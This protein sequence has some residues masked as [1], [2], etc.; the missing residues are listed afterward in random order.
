MT[1]PCL[2]PLPLLLSLPVPLLLNHPVAPFDDLINEFWLRLPL[3]PGQNE[4]LVGV[5]GICQVFLPRTLF[6][7][8]DHGPHESLIAAHCAGRRI[9]VATTGP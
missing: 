9:C 3:L 4:A 8:L 1:T 6:G 7:V 2:L 5:Q